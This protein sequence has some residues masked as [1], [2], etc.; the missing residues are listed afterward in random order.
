VIEEKPPAD[1]GT[2]MDLHSSEE[3][4]GM[5]QHPG[6]KAKPV[7]PNE[8]GQTVKG[9]SMQAGIT[10]YDLGEASRRRI[11]SKDCPNIFS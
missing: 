6:W 7:A 10:Q 8:V 4:V 3:A 5:G 11:P 2:G 9:Q 1:L